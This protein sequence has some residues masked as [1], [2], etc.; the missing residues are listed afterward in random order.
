[1]ARLDGKVAVIT[2]GAAGIGEAAGR[3]FAAEGAK[4]L[5]VDIQEEA[6]K[7]VV[8]SLG[9][10]NVGYVVADVSQAVENQK[11]VKAAVDR[12]GG[13]DILAANAGILGPVAP[14][15]LYPEDAFNKVLAVNLKGAWLS[16]KYAIP[17]LQKRGG[18]SIIIT[19]SIAGVKGFAA[20]PAYSATKHGVIGIMR[21]AAIECAPL[22][23]RVNTIHPGP[24]ETKMVH[25][26]EAGFFPD[27]P[28]QGQQALEGGTLLKRYGGADE[29]AQLMAFL[30]SDD[31]RYC[32]G[33]I[34][35]IDGGMAL[36]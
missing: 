25:D 10:N 5:L 4:V 15:P 23:I 20:V 19:S 3:L 29:V 11:Y 28:S 14:I 24:I 21:T 13:I 8:N 9:N 6:L 7:K 26:L 2:G 33:G 12:F 31:S 1:M 35:M 16:L 32:T 27:D 22:N 36:G 34:Y 17:E 18:G 30:A